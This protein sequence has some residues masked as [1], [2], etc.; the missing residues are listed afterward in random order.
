MPSLTNSML[1]TSADGFLYR[2]D[3]GSNTFTQS[4]RLTGGVG[5]AYTPTA[6]GADGRVYAVSGG[7]LFSIGK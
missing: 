1:V 4:I 5:Q 2:W 6:I 7:V 3:P